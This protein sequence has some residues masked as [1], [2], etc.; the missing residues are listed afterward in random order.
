MQYVLGKIGA[1][2]VRASL[3]GSCHAYFPTSGVSGND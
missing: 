3:Y 1:L 2:D